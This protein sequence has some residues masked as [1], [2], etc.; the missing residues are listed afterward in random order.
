MTMRR[1]RSPMSRLQEMLII[2]LFLLAGVSLQLLVVS[3]GS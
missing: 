3:I 1:R 2:G